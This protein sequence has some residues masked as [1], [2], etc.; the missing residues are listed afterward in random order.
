MTD[1]TEEQYREAMDRLAIKLDAPDGTTD[2]DQE[3]V[4]DY[5]EQ[6]Q[7]DPAALLEAQTQMLEEATERQ[8]VAME[9]QA[10]SLHVIAMSLPLDREYAATEKDRKAAVAAEKG[11]WA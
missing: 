5:V 7:G 9:K 1:I 3:L 8:T 10:H 11:L 6:L 2:P 4:S